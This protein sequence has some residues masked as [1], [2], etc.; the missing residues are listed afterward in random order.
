M[1]KVDVLIEFGHIYM[2]E[3]YGYDQE[4]SIEK[5][6]EID[7][8][9]DSVGYTVLVDNINIKEK[10][11]E[12]ED[13]ITILNNKVEIDF[14]GLEGE[15]KE[16][17]DLLIKNMKQENLIVEKFRNKKVTFYL[18]NGRKIALKNEEVSNSKYTCVMLS[19]CWKLCN[20]GIYKYP[21]NSIMIERRK[22][23]GK[24]VINIL[25]EKYNDVE[26]KVLLIMEDLYGK[27]LISRVENIYY[28]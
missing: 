5:L 24:K 4:R 27:E 25:N 7:K 15:F 6:K 28:L 3:E 11:W 13:L 8:K 23:T 20:L 22:I 21:K 12:I 26:E 16:V 1:N 18:V 2:D 14:I 9:Y 17:A 19:L 10:L